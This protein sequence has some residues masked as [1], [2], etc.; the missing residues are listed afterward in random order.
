MTTLADFRVG[1]NYLYLLSHL[2]QPQILCILTVV[3]FYYHSLVFTSNSYDI[4][5]YTNFSNTHNHCSLH[6]QQKRPALT[7]GGSRPPLHLGTVVGRGRVLCKHLVEFLPFLAEGE[8][9]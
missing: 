3:C 6:F 9:R 1:N 8:F 5:R 2:N 4:V 7:W